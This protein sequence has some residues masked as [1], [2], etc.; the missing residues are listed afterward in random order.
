MASLEK[1]AVS[2]SVASLVGTGVN[3]LL[4]IVQVPLILAK[5]DASTYGIWAVVLGAIGMF[6]VL[7]TGHQSYVGNEFYRLWKTGNGKLEVT[8]GSACI[9]ALIL[10]C[11]ETILGG[12]VAYA[13]PH[14]LGLEAES[15]PQAQAALMI[16]LVGWCAVG[17]VG[18]VLVRLYPPAG[19][20]ARGQWIGAVGKVTGFA[21]LIV[22]I[23]GGANI[24]GAMAALIGAS[25]IFNVYLFVDIRRMLPQLWPW[26]K[27]QSMEV[28]WR[29]CRASL[30]LT[31]SVLCDQWSTN[32]VL[33][34]VAMVL[35][36]LEVAI[37][38]TIRTVTNAFMQSNALF[39]SPLEPDLAR[40]H[41]EHAPGK[42]AA[43]F[44]FSWLTG[45]SL[46]VLGLE[47]LIPAVTSVYGNWTRHAMPFDRG[48]FASLALAVAIRQWA[49]PLLSYV[50][51]INDLVART[52]VSV[53]RLAFILGLSVLFVR[54]LGLLGV[55]IAV[56]ASELVAALVLV[57]ASSRSIRECGG[58]FPWIP[59]S[60]A[61]LQV[62]LCG[63]V[64]ATFTFSSS[65]P[66]LSVGLF[67]PVSAMIIWLA[68]RSLPTEGAQRLKNV[69]HAFRRWIV[70]R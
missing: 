50:S 59:A 8:L 65:S 10:A 58:Q 26:W 18:G 25:L 38:A 17:S 30:A 55:G 7:D 24:V 1:R 39:I 63:V 41:H 70:Q 61:F 6:V 12:S 36:P 21:A 5:W 52:T 37:F 35:T 15:L 57:R 51:C 48:L 60:L 23:W 43:V 20:F 47:M 54:P 11:V 13:K 22:A 14:W 68:W 69:V 42:I 9:A 67:L 28:G 33:L 56:A 62:A 66:F 27:R 29:N 49:A 4:A 3:I 46:V 40:Y 44:S 31:L 2:G 53:L 34:L 64:L 16:Y 45:C 19:M 32:G